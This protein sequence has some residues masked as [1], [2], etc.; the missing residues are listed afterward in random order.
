MLIHRI[1]ILLAFGCGLASGSAGAAESWGSFRGENGAGRST[2]KLPLPA[3][4]GPDRHVVWKTALPAGH[5]SPAVHGKH[6]FISAAEK[7]RLST[8]G[9]DRET[10]AVRWTAAAPPSVLEEIHSI[11]SHAQPSPATDGERVVNFFGSYGLLCYDIDGKEL[12]R[13]PLGPFKNNFG[14]GSS[15]V[16]AAGKVL[17]NQDHDLDSYLAAFDLKSGEP[18]WR[19]ERPEFPR[20]YSTPVI[21]Q[22]GGEP[23]VVVAGTL[24]ARGYRLEDGAAIWSVRGLA[25]IVN[26]T[27]VIGD[28]NTLYIASWSPGADEGDRI[29]MEDW[30]KA[31]AEFDQDRSGAIEK[32]EVPEGA[33]KNRYNQIDRDKNGKV[34][35]A[36]WDY[37]RAIFESARNSAIAIKPGGKGD[38]TDTHVLWREDRNTPYVPSPLYHDGHIYMVKNGG[39]ITSLDAK[40]GKRVKTARGPHAGDYYSS[41]VYGDGKIYLLSQR[42]ELTVISARP[43]WEVLH[44]AEFKEQ[45]YATPAIAGGRIY[46]RTAGWLYCFGGKVE[47]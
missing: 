38:I 16:I 18:L 10:G 31:L 5:G 9:L 47:E 8:I 28:D 42:G 7:D 21:W 33:L 23:Q 39:I 3:Q 40:T 27:P 34:M 45:T 35:R 25:R 32:A 15:P 43:E 19:A 36:E 17:L 11:G 24:Q 12:W 20:G 4:L 22:V 14:A 37:M 13:R 46:L 2:S 6:I 26:T 44:S 30:E 41:P 29:A 1:A